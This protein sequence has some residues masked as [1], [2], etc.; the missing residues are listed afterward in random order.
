MTSMK[1]VV[2]YNQWNGMWNRIHTGIGNSRNFRT[3]YL[4]SYVL[5]ISISDLNRGTKR[6]QKSNLP[7]VVGFKSPYVKSNRLLT[8]CLRTAWFLLAALINR[9]QKVHLFNISSVQSHECNK[10]HRKLLD[11]RMQG[12]K[13]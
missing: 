9:K 8:Y 6:G 4:H 1:S 10:S 7:C 13:H 12:T 5:W 11:T 3:T 2:V